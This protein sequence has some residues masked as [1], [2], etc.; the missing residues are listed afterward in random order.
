[1][2]FVAFYLFTLFVFF[3]VWRTCRAPVMAATWVA[4]QVS[5]VKF[6]FLAGLY[7][8]SISSC[9]G[10]LYGSPRILQC[11]AN[12]DV[13]PFMKVLGQGVSIV[14]SSRCGYLQSS[15]DRTAPL[16]PFLRATADDPRENTALAFFR[17]IFQKNI[18]P[19][20]HSSCC[21]LNL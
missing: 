20:E 14:T 21:I 1:M 17:C 18:K 15:C 4:V 6:L 16:F 19:L 3:F 13:V 12:D 5:I 8:S 10:A 7:I 9:M 2:I 11:I